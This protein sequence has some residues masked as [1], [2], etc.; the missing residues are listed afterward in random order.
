ME[1]DEQGWIWLLQIIS[2]GLSKEIVAFSIFSEKFKYVLLSE[3]IFS[4]KILFSK[5]K[6]VQAECVELLPFML[7]C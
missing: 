3:S 5:K 7:P 2:R 1:T 6:I 4:E